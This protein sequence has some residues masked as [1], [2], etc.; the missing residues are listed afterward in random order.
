MTD[1]LTGLMW[2]KD[3]G[4]LY[5]SWSTALTTIVDFSG[6]PAKYNCAEY[7]GSYSDWRL[8]NMREIESLM[9]FGVSRF[10]KPA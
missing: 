4:C 5:K 3:G 8:P 6:S 1:S 9:N 7:I 10:S 2:L